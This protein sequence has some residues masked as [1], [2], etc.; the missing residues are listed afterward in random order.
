MKSRFPNMFIFEDFTPR[1]L[2]EIALDFSNKNGYILDEGALQLFHE[3]YTELYKNK[4]EAFGNART[5]K[6]I[7]YKAVSNQEERILNITDPD[8]EALCTITY[9]DVEKIDLMEIK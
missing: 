3:I 8:D 2:L 6:N 4:A 7:F 9:E 1:Q 5:V